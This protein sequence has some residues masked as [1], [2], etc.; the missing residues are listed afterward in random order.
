M[1]QIAFPSACLNQFRFDFLQRPR[2]DRL[3]QVVNNFAHRFLCGPGVP[4]LGS[5]IPILDDPVHIHDENGVVG[6]IEEICLGTKTCLDAPPNHGK[7]RE[8]R[9][10]PYKNDQIRDLGPVDVESV[11][12]LHEEPVE[13]DCGQD[14]RQHRRSWPS[15]PGTY[16]HRKQ[17]QSR[18]DAEVEMLEEESRPQCDT[19][20]KNRKPIP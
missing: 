5:T 20:G 10:E 11:D 13:A 12:R 2:E 14:D 18:G 1:Q 8:E 3:E 16:G 6:E 15:I 7:P 4:L 9:S 19:D 17:Q